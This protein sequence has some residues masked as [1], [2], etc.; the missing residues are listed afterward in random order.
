M[1]N[2]EEFEEWA[3][4]PSMRIK[5]DET[6]DTYIPLDDTMTS[7]GMAVTATLVWETW[8]AA[9]SCR[10]KQVEEIKTMVNTLT[11]MMNKNS[12]PE[13][14]FFDKFNK[15]LSSNI[16]NINTKKVEAAAIRKAANE[17]G[18]F[19]GLPHGIQVDELMEYADDLEK[20]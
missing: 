16:D 3:D 8:Q 19:K 13:S 12:P 6:T 18:T 4:I 15:T 14:G 10:T 17:L 1:T 5:F 7:E 20:E 9:Q 2:R 11:N